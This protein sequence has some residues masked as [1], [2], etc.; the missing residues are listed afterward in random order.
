VSRHRHRLDLIDV[1]RRTG[2][3]TRAELAEAA[4][5]SRATVSGLVSELVADGLVTERHEE[6]GSAGATGRR[7]TRLS[8][9]SGLGHVVGVDFG[10]THLRVALADLASTVLGERDLAVDVDRS[11]AEALDAAARLVGELLDAEGVDRGSVV[12][13]GMGLPG[14]IDRE[15][16]VVGSSVILENWSGGRA[17]AELEARLGLPVR[18]DNDANLGA[19]G[20]LTFGAAR[21]AR[22]VVYVKVSSGI[23][24]GMVIDGQ[25]FRGSSGA[26]GELGHVIVDPGGLLCRCGN[27]GCL[28]TVVA[29]GA[30][31]RLLRTTH[32]D[33]ITVAD[34]VE[35]ARTGDVACRRVVG[36]AG[37]AIGQALATICNVFNPDRLV[38]GGELSVAGEPL[39]EGIAESLRRYALPAVLEAAL[40]C[41]GVLGARAEVLGAVRLVVADTE[42]LRSERLVTASA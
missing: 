6:N 26:A 4:G 34:V 29:S 13:V 27:R 3:A 10:H 20:E 35:G 17:A 31:V 22:N 23:G 12:G 15:T 28:E 40:L 33:G 5:L 18:V 1:L 9:A 19:L 7:A 25:V 30:L 39:I 8:L 24:A 14:P 37:R 42:G 36:D 41:Q 11:A 2:D 16:G 32:G 21:G 38:I